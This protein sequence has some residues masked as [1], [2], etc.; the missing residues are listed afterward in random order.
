[1]IRRLLLVGSLAMLVVSCQKDVGDALPSASAE[2]VA[3]AVP[4]EVQA[5]VVKT[6]KRA[7]EGCPH[8]K[9]V[10]GSPH[11]GVREC[12]HAGSGECPH[13]RGDEGN[14]AGC[15][16]CPHDEDGGCA[17]GQG[18]AHCPHCTGGDCPCEHG[19]AGECPHKGAVM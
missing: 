16:Q 10:G 6:P 11:A 14:A 19:G 12:P 18:C 13:A 9:R 7:A 17:Q 1:M 2:A 15:G 5:S 4:A 8:A 3:S